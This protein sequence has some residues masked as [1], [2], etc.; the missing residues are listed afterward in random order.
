MAVVR[1]A[2][3]GTTLI[4]AAGT[5]KRAAAAMRAV[6]FRVFGCNLDEGRLD[7]F[8][9]TMKDLVAQ[10]RQLKRDLR[11]QVCVQTSPFFIYGSGHFAT[12]PATLCSLQCTCS[13][14]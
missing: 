3:R 11:R 14:Y 6:W 8:Q 7:E 2:V 1:T 13:S 5:F 12:R 9:E 10:N 4:T